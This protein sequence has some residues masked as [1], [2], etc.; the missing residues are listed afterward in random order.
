MGGAAAERRLRARLPLRL[1]RAPR[2]QRGEQA[3]GDLR[4]RRIERQ[5]DFGE[6]FIT[7]AVDPIE[8]RLV[9]AEAAD[10]GAHA[11]GIAQRE[12]MMAHQAAHTRQGLFLGNMRLQDEP[13]VEDQRI[14]GMGAGEGLE[15]MFARASPASARARRERRNVRSCCWRRPTDA[16]RAARPPPLCR[17]RA[18]T[19]PHCAGRGARRSRRPD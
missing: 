7:R 6:Q 10:Q 3:R 14:G 4:V 1:Q 17:R 8:L 18:S 19:A 13:F 11:I 12:S 5:H 2:A 16:G 9:G 15:R